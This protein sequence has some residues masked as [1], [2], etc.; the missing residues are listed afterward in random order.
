MDSRGTVN[1]FSWAHGES[2]IS[3]LRFCWLTGRL[4]PFMESDVTESALF[5]KLWAWGDK[6]KKQLLWG[7]IALVVVGMG[8]AFWLAHQSEMQNDANDA[9]SKLTNRGFSA[10]TPE[11]TPEAL[12]KLAADYPNTDAAQRSL[13]LGA[14]ALFDAGKYDEAQAQ[15][16]KFLKDYS[17][18]PL[19]GQAALGAAACLDAQGKTNDAASAYQSVIDRYPNQNVV[20]QARLS[21]AR[22]LEAQ[23]KIKE[24]RN[25]LEEILHT[26]SGT[27][28]SEAAAH[29]Q[30]LNTAHPE[31]TATNASSS[32][33]VPSLNPKP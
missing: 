7:L 15:F 31:V 22:L 20:P 18:S 30:E 8:I 21:L 11:P 1:D 3:S 26:S 14:A 28:G 5:Y 23:G 19:V 9:L 6:N 17:D 32:S 12:L 10:S 2:R 16:Q 13:L 33:P 27:I 24:A 25:N 29:L 4:H